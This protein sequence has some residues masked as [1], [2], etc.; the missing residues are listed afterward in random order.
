[1]YIKNAKIMQEITAK[2]I[3]K[4]KD[5]HDEIT[6]CIQIAQSQ[7]ESYTEK[8]RNF[9]ADQDQKMKQLF[10]D[11]RMKYDMIY[12]YKKAFISMFQD[13]GLSPV[14]NERDFY[15]KEICNKLNKIAEFDIEWMN[16]DQKD[17]LLLS[18]IFDYWV[19]I[20]VYEWR[21]KSK[22]TINY[23]CPSPRSRYPDPN[24]NIFD[25]NFDYHL[26]SRQTSKQELKYKDITQWGYFCLDEVVEWDITRNNTENKQRSN[27]LMWTPQTQDWVVYIRLC[28]ITLNWHRYIATL[29]NDLTKIIKREKIDA[30][31]KEEKANDCIVPFPISLSYSTPNKYDPFWESYREKIK[32]VQ[33]ALT[34]L[35]NAI[36]SKQMRDAWHSPIFYDI[37]R[38]ENPADL[39]MK[40]TW[41]PLFIPSTNL[42]QWL[43]TAPVIE[44]ND[45]TWTSNYI[46]QL[47]QYVNNSTALTWVVRWMWS[48]A[49]TLWETKIQ[50]QRSNAMFSV[51]AKN[52]MFWERKFWTDLYYRSLKQNIRT[53][54]EKVVI[55]S[56]TSTF[57]RLEK[58]EL[59][60]AS[61][62]Y[63]QVISKKEQVEKNMWIVANM[64]ALLPLV[65]QDQNVHPISLKLYKRELMLRQWL[66]ESF[67]LSVEPYTANERHA[68]IM[69]DIINQWMKP[70]SLLVPWIDLQTLWIYINMCIDNDGKEE[71]LTFLNMMMIQEWL[72]KP[73]PV[74]D[75]WNVWWIAN[76]M[77]AQAMSNAIK[78]N[79][80][81]EQQAPNLLD[82]NR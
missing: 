58:S 41:W 55:L 20:R 62:P 11:D 43:L 82:T 65:Q 61:D 49:W 24:W 12:S 32:P 40:P 71:V 9:F 54:K 46:L 63:I 15:D 25:N 27:R 75:E 64:M 77:W 26:F 10:L 13:E 42:W 51:D 31:T 69:Q 52:L 36:H 28:Y 72:E 17:Q 22:Q 67:I 5:L 81:W 14:F 34:E 3:Q 70:K 18:D 47:E 6:L 45:T 44:S 4:N 50:V 21:N 16:K 74:W 19:W 59:F 37:D 1:M 56:D 79:Q 57:I 78:T 33:V 60:W 8:K 30:M 80:Q 48:D 53:I 38:V 66:D 2:E 23:V 29:A 73:K 39:L 35:V 68:K 7:S 76:S